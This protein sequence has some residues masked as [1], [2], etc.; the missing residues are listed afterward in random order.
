MIAVMDLVTMLTVIEVSAQ[1]HRPALF[2]IRHRPLV[3]GQHPL[4]KLDPIGRPIL[5]KYLG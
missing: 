2:D 3:A 4:P 1:S 5:S